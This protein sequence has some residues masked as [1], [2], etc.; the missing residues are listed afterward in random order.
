MLFFVFLVLRRDVPN[1]SSVN[2]SSGVWPANSFNGRQQLIALQ[3]ECHLLHWRVESEQL[4][5]AFRDAQEDPGG[6]GVGLG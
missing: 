5:A 1:Y 2:L 4:C 3:V 6:V